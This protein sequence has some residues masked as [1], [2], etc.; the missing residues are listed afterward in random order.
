MN[1]DLTINTD[2]FDPAI[3]DV[4]DAV[5]AKFDTFCKVRGISP[6][7]IS[8]E[9]HT[10]EECEYSLSTG[11]KV[12]W[13][14]SEITDYAIVNYYF[15]T[16]LEKYLVGTGGI[17]MHYT[18]VGQR[19]CVLIF[20]AKNTPERRAQSQVS[21]HPLRK[22]NK[23]HM[24]H[25]TL[26]WDSDNKTWKRAVNNINK[27]LDPVVRALWQVNLF[28][29]IQMASPIREQLFQLKR[30]V[31]TTQGIE[32]VTHRHVDTLEGKIGMG[33]SDMNIHDYALGIRD[34]PLDIM[35]TAIIDKIRADRILVLSMMGWAESDAQRLFVETSPD[36]TYVWREYD[37]FSRT[38]G[39]VKLFRFVVRDF[40]RTLGKAND[41][42][43]VNAFV[44]ENCN[45]LAVLDPVA[46]KFES[47]EKLGEHRPEWFQ[48]MCT[49]DVICDGENPTIYV[50]G[51]GGCFPPNDGAQ[52]YVL[53]LGES[54]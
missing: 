34:N 21:F 50:E 19:E 17:V 11:S 43:E 9:Y 51:V 25:I 52:L 2:A 30:G 37:G 6:D 4:A 5:S 26:K 53:D 33:R 1:K 47:K 20:H 15:D 7:K 38:G 3:K 27:L 35:D 18:P 13:G 24:S 12:C 23:Y 40:F 39:T 49:L 8:E 48:K 46:Y 29:D 44:R 54:S 36:A 42:N 41:Q 22:Y 14:K 32:R 31:K 10:L 16:G 45:P 28:T